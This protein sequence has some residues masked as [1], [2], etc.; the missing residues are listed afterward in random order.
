MSSE[1]AERARQG[2]QRQRDIAALE[3]EERHATLPPDDVQESAAATA[4]FDGVRK[5]L[6]ASLPPSIFE[7]WV[8]PLRVL[9]E[10]DGA[11]CVVGPRRVTTWVRRRYGR[12]LG[13]AIRG[14]SD[15]R[16]V[17]V[18]DAPVEKR[19]AVECL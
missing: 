3:T 11:V 15:Y 18:Y 16:G 2:S 8:E 17:F 14:L 12:H 13:D 19:E 4:A 7:S 10:R 6:Q 5:V 1:R 9:G